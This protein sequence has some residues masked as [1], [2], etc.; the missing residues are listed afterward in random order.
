M[1]EMA[2][3]AEQ[4]IFAYPQVYA[5]INKDDIKAIVQAARPEKP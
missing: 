4:I 3:G 2:A 1:N 5:T